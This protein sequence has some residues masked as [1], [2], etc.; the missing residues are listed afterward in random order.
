MIISKQK[1]FVFIHNPKVAGSSIR[2]FLS[3]YD[4]FDNFFW[5]RGYI[6]GIDHAVDKPHIPLNDLAKTDYYQYIN[7]DNYFVFGF[8]RN[9]YERVY[10]AYL[11]KQRQWNDVEQDFNQF[12]QQLDE[13]KIRYDY[14][15]IHFCPQHY[16]FYNGKKRLADFVGRIETLEEGFHTV[17]SILSL[18]LENL[19]RINQSNSSDN[20]YLDNYDAKSLLVV[21]QLYEKDF[22]LFGYPMIGSFESSAHGLKSN[23]F[24]DQYDSGS[25]IS[26]LLQRVNSLSLDLSNSH[27]EVAKGQEELTKIQ[28][29]LAKSQEELAKSQKSWLRAK[30]IWFKKKLI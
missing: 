16:F 29:E 21:N 1:K 24:F 20:S 28:E 27:D 18:D 7:S 15:F 17:K 2:N 30:K 19:K 4:S 8:V 6:D 5:H 12:V 3:K 13:I 11:E 9:P 14:N 26:Q 10:S 25:P 22:L 23:S